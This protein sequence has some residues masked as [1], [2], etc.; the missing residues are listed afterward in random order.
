L[1]L[2]DIKEATKAVAPR[3]AHSAMPTNHAKRVV[4][5]ACQLSPFLGKRML[6][7]TFLTRDVF[8]RELMPQDLKLALD[9]L[10]LTEATSAA[11]FL[12]AVLG[13]AHG[14]Q[15]D[16][17]TRVQWWAELSRHRS[18]HLAAPSWLWASV[19]Q[20]VA[21]RESAYLEHCRSYARQTMA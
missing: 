6:A 17:K 20:L 5:G 14:R 7:A 16:V 8:L 18:R 2:I 3:T 1:C 21:A 15:M 12:A 19:I 10:T 13:K 11:R 9:R 4:E